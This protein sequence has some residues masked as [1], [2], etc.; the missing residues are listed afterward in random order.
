VR[1]KNKRADHYSVHWIV[2][3]KASVLEMGLRKRG[4]V[5]RMNTKSYGSCREEGCCSKCNSEQ[6]GRKW[7]YLY[8]AR[9]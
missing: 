4:A 5:E 1:A 8:V 3:F 6:D 9:I 7:R 2:R